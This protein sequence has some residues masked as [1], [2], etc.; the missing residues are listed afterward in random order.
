MSNRAVRAEEAREWA[1]FLREVSQIVSE[2]AARYAT[3]HAL[4]TPVKRADGGGG[5]GRVVHP[6]A[7]A[8]LAVIDLIGAVD[9]EIDRLVS[10]GLGA[11][12]RGPRVPRPGRSRVRRTGD[13]LR[14]LDATIRDVWSDD[15]D[16]GALIVDSLWEMRG[17]LRVLTGEGP[18]SYRTSK[19]CV[20]CGEALV[21]V[22]QSRGRSWC[23]G[24]GNRG[25]T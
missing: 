14:F 7:P 18:G 22:D 17:R 21:M 9:Q 10:L 25:G 16:T 2:V 11:L 1:R 8:D 15:P 12:K 24:C 3:L 4:V 19:P 23:S 6:P 5:G 20:A 13:G